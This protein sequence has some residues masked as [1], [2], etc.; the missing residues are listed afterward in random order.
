MTQRARNAALLLAL[1]MILSALLVACQPAVNSGETDTDDTSETEGQTT[2]AI[3]CTI[4]VNEMMGSELHLHVETKTGDRL[5]IRIPT[6]SPDDEAR[7]GMVYGATIYVT[8]EGKVMH[9]FDTKT[10]QNLLV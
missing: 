10:Q 5:I 2:P 8:F 6:V 7:H 9:F 3:P 1:L 4:K